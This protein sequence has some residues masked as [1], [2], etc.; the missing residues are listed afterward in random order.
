MF[1]IAYAVFPRL[2][3]LSWRFLFS[4]PKVEFITS[5]NPLYF[6]IQN[7][8]AAVDYQQFLQS[9]LDLTVPLSKKVVLLAKPGGIEPGYGDAHDMTVRSINKRTAMSAIS[10]IYSDR[11]S[12]GLQRLVQEYRSENPYVVRIENA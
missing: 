10:H 6:Y 2:V 11:N 8:Q 9:D 3:H 7:E 5:D 12:D 4:S 1:S